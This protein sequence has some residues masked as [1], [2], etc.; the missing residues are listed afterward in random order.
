VIEGLA[1]CFD[2]RPDQVE[3]VVQFRRVCALM[4]TIV[5]GLRLIAQL[6]IRNMRTPIAHRARLARAYG[7]G[8]SARL[9]LLATGRLLEFSRAGFLGAFPCLQSGTSGQP[10]REGTACARSIVQRRSPVEAFL[11]GRIGF[12]DIPVYHRSHTEPL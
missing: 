2:A 5:D 8:C 12:T 1:G 10:K 6:V 11:T 9:D 4:S 7:S 3:V